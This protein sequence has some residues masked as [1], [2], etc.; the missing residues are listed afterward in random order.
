MF[1]NA[2]ILK[3]IKSL[4]LFF[5]LNS[6]YFLF[7]QYFIKIFYLDNFRKKPKNIVLKKRISF[8]VIFLEQ[9]S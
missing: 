8:F 5:Q 2:Y 1:L 6:I 4:A 9:F 7:L 3:Y